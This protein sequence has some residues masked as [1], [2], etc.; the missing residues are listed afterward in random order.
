MEAEPAA[1]VAVS[2]WL[3]LA[4]GVATGLLS[5]LLGVG[6]GI[7]MVPALVALGYTRHR[8]NATSLASI[9][10]VAL[11]GTISFALAGRIDWRV[12]LLLGL[13]GIVGSTA[14]ATL[15]KHLSGPMLGTIFG[16]VLLLAGLRMAIGGDLA[17]GAITSSEVWKATI[18]I[19]IGALAGIASGLAGVGGG[20]VMVPAMVFLLG[21]DQHTAEGTSLLA[22]LFTAI[23]ATRVNVGNDYVDWRAMGILGVVGAATAPLATLLAL[24]IPAVTL[25]RVFGLFL[26]AIAIQT[27]LKNRKAPEPVP[28]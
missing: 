5:G 25:S 24:Q 19:V 26:I 16:I 13:G 10:L 27:I 28:A 8:A 22:I 12:G 21:V 15:M 17:T 20:T 14:G 3:M 18:E 6:G 2:W 4:I 1:R 7:V 23:A 9:V 11:A